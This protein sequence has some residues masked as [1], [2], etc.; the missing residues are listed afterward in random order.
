MVL[1]QGG[2]VGSSLWQGVAVVVWIQIY[3]P[4]QLHFIRWRLARGEMGLSCNQSMHWLLCSII[5]V[6]KSAIGNVPVPKGASIASPT[7]A[8]CFIYSIGRNE[9]L[10]PNVAVTFSSL[11]FFFFHFI[12]F[13]FIDG[14]FQFAVLPPRSRHP[15]ELVKPT[16]GGTSQDFCDSSY[17]SRVGV[18]NRDSRVRAET[19]DCGPILLLSVTIRHHIL[20]F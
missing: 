15:A 18:L 3:L 1:M 8:V 4:G 20:T 11:S 5:M 17:S 13:H 6:S 14:R 2:G 16:G 12:H 19:R 10:G 9:K 7:A